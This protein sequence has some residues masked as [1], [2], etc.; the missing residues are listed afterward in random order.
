MAFDEPR[1]ATMSMG[2][3]CADARRPST[4]DRISDES[5]EMNANESSNFGQC[6]F[7]ISVLIMLHRDCWLSSHKLRAGSHFCNT[8]HIGV[9]IPGTWMLEDGQLIV[10]LD[11][12]SE[13]KYEINEFEEEIDTG[14]YSGMQLRRISSSSRFNSCNFEYRNFK[15]RRM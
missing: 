13:A 10:E 11:N 8:D 7:L 3:L 9:Y 4:G 2:S 6:H 1:A 5:F 15:P 12:V 14:V